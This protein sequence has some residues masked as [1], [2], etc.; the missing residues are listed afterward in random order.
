M[1]IVL[2]CRVSGTSAVSPSFFAPEF[3]VPHG[4]CP[5]QAPSNRPEAVPL[6]T[7]DAASAHLAR[8]GLRRPPITDSLDIPASPPSSE[9]TAH[10]VCFAPRASTFEIKVRLFAIHILSDL[11]ARHSHPP[12]CAR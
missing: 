5:S 6:S 9:A 10:C 12:L 1:S 11:H 3:F 4:H 7:P 8:C 2:A